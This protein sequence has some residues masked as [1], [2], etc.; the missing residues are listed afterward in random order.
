[1]GVMRVI[2]ILL[3]LPQAGTV[4]AGWGWSG[5]PVGMAFLYLPKQQPQIHSGRQGGSAGQLLIPGI[6][7]TDL[8]L[9]AD[10]RGRDGLLS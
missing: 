10:N 6:A 1:M 5:S 7:G 2:P 8:Y 3:Q 9:A 4:L